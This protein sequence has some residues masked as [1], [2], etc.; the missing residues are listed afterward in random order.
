MPV[1]HLVKIK[2]NF[3]SY[4]N[5]QKYIIIFICMCNINNVNMSYYITHSQF[6]YSCVCNLGL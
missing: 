6:M 4:T 5:S 2:Y 3:P 1:I